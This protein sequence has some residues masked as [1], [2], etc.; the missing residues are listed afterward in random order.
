MAIV[1][2]CLC[3]LAWAHVTSC[4]QQTVRSDKSHSNNYAFDSVLVCEAR[5]N[6]LDNMIASRT[7]SGDISPALL[8]ARELRSQAADL[9]LHS[10]FELALELISQAI[11][12]LGVPSP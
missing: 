2:F 12:L 1:A 3:V 8:E 7:A 10:E 6:D 5:L 4:S 9:Y 11:S